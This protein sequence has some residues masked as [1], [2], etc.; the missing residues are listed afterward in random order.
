MSNDTKSRDSTRRIVTSGFTTVDVIANGSVTASPGGTATNVASILARLGWESDV[1][2]TVGDDP[3]GEFLIGA[4]DL[5]G[6]GTGHLRR[7]DDWMT[8]IVVQER[9]QHDHIWRFACPVCGARFAKHRPS[10]AAYADLIVDEIQAPNV[11][12]FDRVSLFTLRLASIWKDAGSTVFFEPAT[13][14][15]PA[16]F[17][18][19]IELADVIKYSSERAPAF[20]NRLE[21]LETT[22]V[23]TLG[24][25]G[26]KVRLADGNRW[27]PV[28]GQRVEHLVDSAGA[29]DWTTAGI[30]DTLFASVGNSDWYAA[31]TVGQRLGARSCGWEG[32]RPEHPRK[33]SVGF[34]QFGCP[35]VLESRRSGG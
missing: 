25:E 28:P 4:L 3:A 5:E 19:A 12:F 17:E 11:F 13:L 6:V 20:E 34:E 27:L 21:R 10:E 24:G 18:R 14:G 35:R 29:G 7:F 33:L 8:P 2:G 26:A 32:V 30:I 31:L 16:L 9:H 1:V 15:R 23:E 22:L